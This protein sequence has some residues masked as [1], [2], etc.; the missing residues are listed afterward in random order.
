[1]IIK[2]DFDKSKHTTIVQFN[3]DLYIITDYGIIVERQKINPYQ[4]I[5]QF[6]HDTSARS[7][8]YMLCGFLSNEHDCDQFEEMTKDLPWLKF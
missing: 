7:V 5:A 4:I 6:L 3:Y 8:Y 2:V 1:M